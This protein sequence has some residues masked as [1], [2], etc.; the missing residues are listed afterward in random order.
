MP[1]VGVVTPTLDA[2]RAGRIDRVRQ[3]RDADRIA[4]LE[5][6]VAGMKIAVAQADVGRVADTR[7][8]GTGMGDGSYEAGD[9]CRGRADRIDR[10]EAGDHCHPWVEEGDHTQSFDRAG[11]DLGAAGTACD[12][13]QIV[14]GKAAVGSTVRSPGVLVAWSLGCV[15]TAELGSRMVCRARKASLDAGPACSLGNSWVHGSQQGWCSAR[16]RSTLDTCLSPV[17][18]A[19]V[20]GRWMAA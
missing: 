1:A 14:R 8:L 7:L 16:G 6:V 3:D 20:A 19:S 13:A 4:A 12:E 17:E 18:C 9:S 15:T 11:S 2:H 5:N 10:Q